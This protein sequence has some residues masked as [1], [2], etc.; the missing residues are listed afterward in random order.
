MQK[1]SAK[2][3]VHTHHPWIGGM[4]WSIHMETTLLWPTPT[5][6]SEK[7]LFDRYKYAKNN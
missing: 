6:N 5:I 4:E 7:K 1:I 2:G 3:T